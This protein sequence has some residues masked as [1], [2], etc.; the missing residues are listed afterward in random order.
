[1]TICRLEVI[2]SHE[3]LH[4]WLPVFFGMFVVARAA[5]AMI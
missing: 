1:M 4:V 5:A 2:L 3:R